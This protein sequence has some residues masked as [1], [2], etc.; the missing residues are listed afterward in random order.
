[1]AY[2]DGMGDGVVKWDGWM[3]GNS[4]GD[5]FC[6]GEFTWP[7]S[8]VFRDLQRSGNWGTPE[9]AD[10]W[11]LTHSIPCMLYYIPTFTIRKTTTLN[12]VLYSIH[13]SY[14]IVLDPGWLP[15][16]KTCIAL[17]SRLSHHSLQKSSHHCFLF[18]GVV[19]PT[20]WNVETLSRNR[21]SGKGL[22]GWNLVEIWDTL[23]KN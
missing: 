3:L 23:P 4:A 16:K 10:G 14:G 12:V 19:L 2:M 21:N 13:G 18:W 5:L 20:A 22:C 7:L 17:I 15:K 8:K 6:D 1:M 11:N 9:K